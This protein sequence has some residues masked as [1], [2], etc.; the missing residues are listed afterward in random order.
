MCTMIAASTAV[1]GAGKA[2]DRWFPV[3]RATVGYDHASH[4]DEEHALLLDFT[5]Y[6]IGVDARIALELDL[7]SGRALLAQ[8]QRAIEEAEASGFADATSPAR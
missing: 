6:E 5:N 3:T 8:L 2:G 7:R 1:A 4:S